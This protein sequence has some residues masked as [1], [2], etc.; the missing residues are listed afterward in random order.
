MASICRSY[1][2]PFDIGYDKAYRLLYRIIKE[3]DLRRG[4]WHALDSKSYIVYTGLPEKR[5]IYFQIPIH[6]TD[7]RLLESSRALK[8]S[9]CCPKKLE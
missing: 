5:K 7:W 6:T 9:I 1:V 2:T 8:F 4:H 3:D